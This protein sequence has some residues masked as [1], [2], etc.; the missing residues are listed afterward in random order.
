MGTLTEVRVVLPRALAHIN[1]KVGDLRMEVKVGKELVIKDCH[2]GTLA[3]WR[4]GGGRSGRQLGGSGLCGTE[5]PSRVRDL[6]R[7]GWLPQPL[8]LTVSWLISARGLR[9]GHGFG[10]GETGRGLL[11]QR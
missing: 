2:W 9:R 4:V 3:R 1:K 8:A 6:S 5:T 7:S 10:E 11:I